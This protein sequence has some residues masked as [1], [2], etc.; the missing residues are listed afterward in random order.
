[1]YCYISS[2]VEKETWRK[3]NIEKHIWKHR[4][5]FSRVASSLLY[6]SEQGKI[7][8]SYASSD[9]KYLYHH[10]Y[11]PYLFEPQLL[12]IKLLAQAWH[13]VVPQKKLISF[14]SFIIILLRLG[15]LDIYR[16]FSQ[17]KNE[18][19]RPTRIQ[20]KKHVLVSLE[21]HL[22]LFSLTIS[23]FINFHFS[24]LFSFSSHDQN[25]LLIKMGNKFFWKFPLITW[26][27]ST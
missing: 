13:I 21:T 20:G 12:S 7:R 1:M 16:D 6:S 10:R 18:V 25:M 14:I 17:Y 19:D 22:N 3:T 24:L 15:G 26:L 23:L 2:R 27:R 4:K 8:T 5:T 9:T 11:I